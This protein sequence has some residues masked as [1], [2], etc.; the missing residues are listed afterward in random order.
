MFSVNP[1]GVFF[2][3]LDFFYLLHWSF[4]HWIPLAVCFFLIGLSSCGAWLIVLPRIDESC[5]FE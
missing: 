5:G 3:C 1:V 2:C 4:I